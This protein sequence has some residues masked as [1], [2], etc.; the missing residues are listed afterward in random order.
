MRRLSLV[1]LFAVSALPLAAQDMQRIATLTLDEALTLAKRYNPAYLSSINTRRNT[2]LSVRTAKAALFPTVS[3][4]MDFSWR[5]G[6]PTFIEGQQFGSSADALGSSYSV[7][8]GASYRYSTF[9]APKQAAARLD[10]AEFS[11]TAQELSVRQQV[12]S[13][14]FTAVQSVRNAELQDSLV[15]SY[16]LQFDLAKARETVGSGISL[17]TKNAEVAYL[18]QQLAA[19]RSHNTADLDKIRL[20][21]AIGIA[22]QPGVTLTT[23][24]PVTEPRF[25]L[26]DLL[27]EANSKNA[28]LAASRATVRSAEFGSKMSKSAYIPSLSLS[29]GIGGQT[30]MQTDAEG[31]ARTWP[32]GF[33][34]NPLGFRVGLSL[35]LWDGFNREANI[36][37]SAIALSNAQHDVRR[38]ELQLVTNVTTFHTELMYSW[39]QMQLQ[40]EIVEAARQALTLAQERYRLGSTAFTD[41]SLAQDRYQQEQNNQLANTYAYHRAF[42]QLEAAVGRPLR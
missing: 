6:K 39:R 16:K 34:R 21:E 17:D 32:F 33:S 3:S 1:M 35:P 20:F 2:A 36:E 23:E 29:T 5:E 28:S 22:A 13:Q 38:A 12:T 18:R 9:L 41:L 42:A 27:V 19:Q 25:T 37:S 10:A 8:L 11:S 7:S 30:N 26:A 31:D 24:L 4:G 15:S 14:Y 40:R